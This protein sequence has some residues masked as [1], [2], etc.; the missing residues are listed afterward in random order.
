[1]PKSQ[2]FGGKSGGPADCHGHRADVD[3]GHLRARLS[4]KSPVPGGIAARRRKA[5]GDGREESGGDGNPGADGLPARGAS[6]SCVL[7]FP[8]D[9]TLR[10]RVD[11][12]PG[13]QGSSTFTF[14]RANVRRLVAALK[15]PFNVF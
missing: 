10:R 13:R 11:S 12:G 2:G 5:E 9:G 4:G 8:E 14:S 6:H 1:M 3:P 7:G 15:R